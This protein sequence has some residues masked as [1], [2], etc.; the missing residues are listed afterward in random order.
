S[1][2]PDLSNPAEAYPILLYFNVLDRA[3]SSALVLFL[4]LLLGVVAWFRVPMNRNTLVIAVAFA[5]DFTIRAAMLL[6][7]NSLGHEVTQTVSMI[8]MATATACLLAT[9]VLLSRKGE[10]RVVMSRAGLGD[11]RRIS[12]QLDQLIAHLGS[13]TLKR[14]N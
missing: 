4:I 7:R 5:V 14:S 3:V 2:A 12:E 9:V 8:A 1:L 10:Q 6:I 13:G 11:P